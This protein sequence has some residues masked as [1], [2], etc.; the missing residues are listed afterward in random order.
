MAVAVAQAGSY[1]SDSTPSLG[2]PICCRC[3]SKQNK[4]KPSCPPMLAQETLVLDGA[5]Q[6]VVQGVGG[7]FSDSFDH[8]PQCNMY[9]I[10]NMHTYM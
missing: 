10:S 3:G 1:S 7:V 6:A 2:T 9:F 8:S 5:P 4:T